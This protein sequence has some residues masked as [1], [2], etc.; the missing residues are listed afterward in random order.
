MPDAKHV[1]STEL[2]ENV[3]RYHDIALT[4]PVIITS[5]GREPTVMISAEEYARLTRGGR[6]VFAAGELPA[7]LLN[8]IEISE[9]D[10]RHAHLDRLIEDEPT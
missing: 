7:S 3:D 5:A 9:M 10:E 1:S 8:L 2:V 4:R 6:R